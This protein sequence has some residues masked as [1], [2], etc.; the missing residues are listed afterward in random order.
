MAR[1]DLESTFDDLVFAARENAYIT[2]PGQYGS[3]EW[4]AMYASSL[5]SLTEDTSR[6]LT[7]HQYKRIRARVD[8]E[9][10]EHAAAIARSRA[11][12]AEYAAILAENERVLR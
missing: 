11:S 8:R 3:Y 1:F 6:T 2:L 7:A 5:C 9:L 4:E 12:D 10:R